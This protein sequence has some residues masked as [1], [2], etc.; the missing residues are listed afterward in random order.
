M[1]KSNLDLVYELL[2][3]MTDDEIV[4]AT[5]LLQED[6]SKYEN[7]YTNET[8]VLS[9]DTKIKVFTGYNNGVMCVDEIKQMFN[10]TL[11]DWDRTIDSLN[12]KINKAGYSYKFEIYKEENDMIFNRANDF[13]LFDIIEMKSGIKLLVTEYSGKYYLSGV[14]I[15]EYSELTDDLVNELPIT[16][17]YRPIHPSALTKLLYSN[18][19]GGYKMI[20]EKPKELELTL[21]EIAEKFGVKVENLKIKK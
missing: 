9:D 19:V 17:I 11:K 15:N 4:K 16:K 8:S 21:D 18:N 10:T 3:T 1:K 6:L 5:P 7:K 14:D 2:L 12:F 20:W 13:N